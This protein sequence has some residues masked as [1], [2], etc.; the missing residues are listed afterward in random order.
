MTDSDSPLLGRRI[1]NIRLLNVIGEGGMGTVYEGFDERLQRRVAVKA[2]RSAHRFRADIRGR[3][4]R[5]ARI[6][7]QLKHPRICTVHDSIED[8]QY[9]FLVL[10]LI[11][12]R[13]LREAMRR[14]LSS[15][16]RL[17]IARQLLDVLVAVHHRGVIHRD[18]KPENVMVEPEGGIKV[19][20]FGLARS[21]EDPRPSLPGGGATDASG[22]VSD[23]GQET[24]VLEVGSRPP[25]NAPPGSGNPTMHTMAGAILG[26][27][28]Y[29]SPEQARGE[30]ATP[31]SDIYSLG[32][33]F[34]ELFTGRPVAEE[35]LD[36]VQKLLRA[37]EGRT[38]DV[39]GVDS[40]LEDLIQRMKSA[41]PGPRPSAV[42]AKRL[43]EAHIDRPR[44]RRKRAVVTTV[45]AV[46]ILFAA[47]AGIQS[48]R[49]V[50]AAREAEAQRKLAV[51]ARHQAEE[52]LSFMLI[53]LAGSLRPVGKLPLLEGVADTALQYFQAL[54]EEEIDATARR[55]RGLA[56]RQVGQVLQQQGNLTGALEAF[57]EAQN[58][59]ADVVVDTSD[60]ETELELKD[61]LDQLGMGL[62]GQGEYQQALEAFTEAVHLAEGLLD[63]YPDDRALLSEKAF[64]LNAQGVVLSALGEPAR[65]LEVYQQ[66]LE[67][68][69]RL[70]DDAPPASPEQ[71][72][73]AT[74]LMNIGVVLSTVGRTQEAVAR[75]A[76]S[77]ETLEGMIA[78]EPDHTMALKQ[79]ATVT[80]NLG[81][82]LS[83]IGDH[84][85]ALRTHRASLETM[86]ALVEHDP[87]NATWQ[88]DRARSF[89][90]I[91]A[92]LVDMRRYDDALEN[93]QRA[94]RIYRRL[95]DQDPSNAIW[96]S[97]VAT[98]LNA[99]AVV[100]R[101]LGRVDRSVEVLEE[102]R[103]WCEHAV[104]DF[105]DEALMRRNLGDVHLGAADAYEQL[106]RMD[107]ALSA[108]QQAVEVRLGMVESDPANA[109]WR[110]DLAQAQSGVG[111]MLLQL[112]RA[113][114]ARP[115]LDEAVGALERLVADEPEWVRARISLVETLCVRGRADRAEGDLV[116]A[117]QAWDRAVAVS[118]EAGD[119]GPAPS[120]LLSAQVNARLLLGDV[121]GVQADLDRLRE[122]D[123]MT[124]ENRDLAVAA[125]LRV[126]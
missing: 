60:R 67:T 32:L 107:R 105:P 34:Q 1:G 5:E 108:A 96:R 66:S 98:S 77:L 112:S 97:D 121:A 83:E 59:A 75:Y 115:V 51:T 23:P 64:S 7:S 70:A 21:L 92:T 52:L 119:D 55:Q 33:V 124:S 62:Y 28:D 20:D 54:P 58:I 44:R 8:E 78:A 41:E 87:S 57:Q 42:D 35:G 117:H 26:T 3:F 91:G 106:G 79:K 18:L 69:R 10:E 80:N 120:A 24:A 104:A 49:A 39:E 2:I 76:E 9:D 118:R 95:A 122:A 19:L 109:H 27:V 48:I 22:A 94:L 15:D 14:G 36:P 50:R 72:A 93:Q 113:G 38:P 125:G 45:W 4:L 71:F 25:P 126:E 114:D 53:D 101:K 13:N 116:E 16:R 40:D 81:A 56:L 103:V 88:R 68:R 90:N 82:A 84:D 110:L 17:A 11:D 111:R 47:G 65:T 99:I 102:V 89:A 74:S 30:P 12:G 6:L 85:A 46:L 73:V 31:A 43:L 29:M 86:E 100:H 123:A 63:R 37:A 61:A